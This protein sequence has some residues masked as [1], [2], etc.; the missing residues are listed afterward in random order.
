MYIN[1]YNFANILTIFYQL[2]MDYVTQTQMRNHCF[3][4][5]FMR[6]RQEKLEANVSQ[7]IDQVLSSPVDRG[8]FVSVDHVI[9]MNRLRHEGKLPQMSAMRQQMWHEI[10]TAIDAYRLNNPKATITEASCNVI[11]C[12]KASRFYISRRVAM[13]IIKNKI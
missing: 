3:R 10:F 12:G 9:V 2:I 13:D 5:A 4:R 6:A 1:T 8:F 7:L 11:A